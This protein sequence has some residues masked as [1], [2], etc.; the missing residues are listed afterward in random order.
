MADRAQPA[1]IGDALRRKARGKQPRDAIGAF[2]EHPPEDAVP[3]GFAPSGPV[4]SDDVPEQA[5]ISISETVKLVVAEAKLLIEAETELVK[6][7]AQVAAKATQHSAIWAGVALTAM[8]AASLAALYAAI[9][10]LTPWL[11]AAGAATLVA[12]IWVV[13]GVFGAVQVRRIARKA[14]DQIK[15]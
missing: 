4:T 15:D 10:F 2:T 9:A 3:H 11:G 5:G 7:K 6:A 12:L 8:I 14:I 1:P 13:I